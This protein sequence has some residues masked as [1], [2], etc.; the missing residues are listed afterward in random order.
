MVDLTALEAEHNH[1]SL[2][3]QTG[4][5]ALTEEFSDWWFGP[6]DSMVAQQ[7]LV[8]VDEKVNALT[9]RL[10]GEEPRDV[11]NSVPE[12]AAETKLAPF[13]PALSEEA[14]A[15]FEPLL[16]TWGMRIYDAEM[17]ERFRQRLLNMAYLFDQAGQPMM[18]NLAATAAWGLNPQRGFPAA[19]HPFL[20]ELLQQSVDRYL[21]L[22]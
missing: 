8:E 3:D 7:F 20:R 14:K 13:A 10:F 5:L 21:M 11:Q 22:G 16:D 4:V 2:L 12:L 19:H 18:C 17:T 9:G 6:E 15:A 1:P